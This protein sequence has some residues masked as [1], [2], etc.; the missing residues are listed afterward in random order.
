MLQYL[1][2]FLNLNLKVGHTKK[3]IFSLSYAGFKPIWML[4]RYKMVFYFL[5]CSL[6]V[7]F[8]GRVITTRYLTASLFG[9]FHNK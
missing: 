6:R 3:N 4:Q 7:S 9:L 2:S 8:K 1:W 5:W